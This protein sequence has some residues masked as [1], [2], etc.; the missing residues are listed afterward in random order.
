MIRLCTRRQAVPFRALLI[1]LNE[2]VKA[3]LV[4][5]ISPTAHEPPVFLPVLFLK[6][7]FPIRYIDHKR[8]FGI[9]DIALHASSHAGQG[10]VC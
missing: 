5:V 2:L 10:V 1:A 4:G 8:L 9:Q 7:G 6:D 3:D